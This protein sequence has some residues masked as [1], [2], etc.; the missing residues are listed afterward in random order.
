MNNNN[1]NFLKVLSFPPLVSGM[2]R[3]FR[4]IQFPNSSSLK[5]NEAVSTKIPKA[6]GTENLTETD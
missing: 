1:N 5:I 2:H 4:C 3:R 6:S